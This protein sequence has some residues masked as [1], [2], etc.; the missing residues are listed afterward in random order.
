M[1]DEDDAG[2]LKVGYVTLNMGVQAKIHG[3]GSD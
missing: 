1:V 3:A 2:H